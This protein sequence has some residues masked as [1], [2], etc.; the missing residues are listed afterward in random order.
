MNLSNQLTLSRLAMAL[1]MSVFLTLP[2]PFGKTIGLGIFLVAALTDFWDGRLARRSGTVTAFGQLMDPL[3]DKVLV[4]SAF[5]SFVANN[6]IV[7]AWIVIIILTREFIVTGVRLLA[8]NQGRVVPVSRWGKHK[9]LW[10]MIVI[11]LIIAGLAGREDL[12][13]F[14]LQT[15]NVQEFRD[16]YYDRYFGY[17]TLWLSAMVAVFTLFS[18]T[19]YL[20]QFRKVISEK[21]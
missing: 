16:V 12:L 5:V 3:V 1:V 21:E 10:Q 4:C 13:P 18:G 2:I 20:W 7:P 14:F 15:G 11:T 9:T 19:L 8:A 17:L 6:Q